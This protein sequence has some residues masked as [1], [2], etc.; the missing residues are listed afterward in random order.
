[1]PLSWISA[2]PGKPLHVPNLQRILYNNLWQS[3]WLPPV[4]WSS[5]A[6]LHKIVKQFYY[7]NEGCG[8][9][10][11]VSGGLD[12]MPGSLY[13]QK[14][15]YAEIL[16]VSVRM[17]RFGRRRPNVLWFRMIRDYLEGL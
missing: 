5:K 2:C 6:A 9:E 7:G 17:E 13:S 4:Y 12:F 8:F 3:Y 10:G 15:P 11:K 1:M 16:M 14:F